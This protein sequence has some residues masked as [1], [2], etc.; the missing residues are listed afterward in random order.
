MDLASVSIKNFFKTMQPARGGGFGHYRDYDGLSRPSQHALGHD[1]GSGAR[2][3]YGGRGGGSVRGRGFRP[4][5]G[6]GPSGRYA[7]LGFIKKS[8]SDDVRDQVDEL[9]SK[10]FKFEDEYDQWCLPDP[11]TV[12]KEEPFHVVK[13]LELKDQLNE[14]KGRLNDKELVSW[15]KHT[16]FTNRA[17][18]IV[19]M[20]RREFQTEMCTQA[21]AKFHEILWTFNIVPQTASKYTSVHLCEAPGAFIASLNHFLKTH[22]PDCDWSWKAMTLNPYYEGNDPTAMIDQDKFMVETQEHW[23][24]GPENSGNVVSWENVAGLKELVKKDLG[25][26]HLVSWPCSRQPDW[27][28]QKSFSSL[29]S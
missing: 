16:H 22:R 7:G 21:W 5:G 19:S 28:Q 24:H 25:D 26:V 2:G 29:F 17:G 1:S 27:R 14:I 20:L 13:L 18:V 11:S 15:H 4:R 10:K 9:F 8:Y 6:G 23:H 3:S 12:F